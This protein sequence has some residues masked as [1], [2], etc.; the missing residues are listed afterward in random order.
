MNSTKGPTFSL[1]LNVKKRLSDFKGKREQGF[2]F[3]NLLFT[4]TEYMIRVQVKD[5]DRWNSDDD[6]DTLIHRVRIDRSADQ[7]HI[8]FTARTT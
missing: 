5:W 4:Q 3:A 6:V 1:N 8:T 2:N 7:Q